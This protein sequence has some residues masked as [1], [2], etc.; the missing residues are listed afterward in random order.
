MCEGE[1]REQT[2]AHTVPVE[3]DKGAEVKLSG[4]VI[5]CV[6]IL[7]FFQGNYLT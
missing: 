4:D 7:D 6:K 2:A 1:M 3:Y 5:R